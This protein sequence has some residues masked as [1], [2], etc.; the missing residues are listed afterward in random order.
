VPFHNALAGGKSIA[1]NAAPETPP[2]K[3]ENKAMRR[4]SVLLITGAMA[5]ALIALAV[6][7][8][9]RAGRIVAAHWR[10]QLETVS[11]RRAGA[12][13]EEVGELGEPGI[14]IL[15]EA[16]GSEREGVA[17]ASKRVLRELLDRWQTAGTGGGFRKQAVLADA[18]AS[19][20]GA[21]GPAAR[22]NAAELATQILLWL[23]DSAPT[24]ERARVIGHCEEILRAT[25]A[26]DEL[27]S[28]DALADWPIGGT[29][30]S[31]DLAFEDQEADRVQNQLAEVAEEPP[32]GVPTA[33]AGLLPGGGLHPELP[34]PGIEKL[35]TAGVLR[36]RLPRLARPTDGQPTSIDAAEPPGR[37]PDDAE[38]TSA[39]P[40]LTPG[41]GPALSRSP[42]D[43][44]GA[45]RQRSSSDLMDEETVELM[46]RLRSADKA[47]A[48]EA[49]AELMRRGFKTVHLEL[50]RMLFDPDPKVRKR[51]AHAL[52]GMTSVD[53]VPWMWWLSRDS[54]PEVRLTAITLM[55]TTGDPALLERLEE[56]A[57]QDSDP[58]IQ[59]QAAR[60]TQ[61]GLRQ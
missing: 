34:L 60:I 36:G 8:R 12:L 14:P 31:A 2:A 15:V 48:S 3:G 13:L 45:S 11:D 49:E 43:T 28:G 29:G 17:Q 52:P 58:R 57:R 37:L 44:D 32:R 4:S 30:G 61:Q 25:V 39:T 26:E 51:L 18:L 55:A 10:S 9:G 53:A 22:G 6:G 42:I 1:E 19:R 27:P 24:A 16:L 33:G 38:G 21:F 46:R 5:V 50:A 59:H 35:E 47:A 56:I 41:S 40:E 54:D 7:L 20:L 23:P